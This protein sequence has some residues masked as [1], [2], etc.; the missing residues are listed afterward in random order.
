MKKKIKKSRVLWLFRPC[1]P[2]SAGREIWV[3]NGPEETLPIRRICYESVRKLFPIGL[4]KNQEI[5]VKI[6]IEVIE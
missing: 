2:Y 6:T 4:R 3:Y 1:G 5:K